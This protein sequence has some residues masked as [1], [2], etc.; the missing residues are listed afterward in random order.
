[1]DDMMGKA[2]DMLA[3]KKESLHSG[4]DKVADMVDEK[5][6]GKHADKVDKAQEALKGAVDKF[7]TKK[8]GE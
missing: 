3:D 1:M 4:I 6:D 2:K 5:T 7:A 8:P